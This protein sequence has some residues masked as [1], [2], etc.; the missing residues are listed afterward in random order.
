MTNA[1]RTE[2]RLIDLRQ[3]LWAHVEGCESCA[4]SKDA[5]GIHDT[6][7]KVADRLAETIDH[8]N[9]SLGD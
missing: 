2:I 4:E 1:A 3:K 8:L 6:E 9:I 7:C 5:T